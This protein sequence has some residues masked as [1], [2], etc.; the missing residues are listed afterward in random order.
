MVGY[1]GGT[2]PAPTYHSL[3]DHTEAVR[4]EYD[5]D[6]ISY[7][8]LL[9]IFWKAHDP[10]RPSAS[11]QYRSA[12]FYHDERQKRAAQRGL[13]RAAARGAGIYTEIFP[14]AEFY[15]AEPYHQK[16]YLRQHPDLVRILK[17]LRLSGG[18]KFTDSTAAARINGFLGGFITREELAAS[19]DACGLS[20]QE[21]DR[22]M[23]FDGSPAGKPGSGQGVFRLPELGVG[24]R[25]AG[26]GHPRG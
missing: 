14:V 10:I 1:T 5:P 25:Q 18:K 15:P 16:F 3:G 22:V 23:V 11:R 2:T 20:P 19:L 13:D 26:D 7:E 8:R 9:D 17:N 24:G 6:R 12:V 4:I 21:R